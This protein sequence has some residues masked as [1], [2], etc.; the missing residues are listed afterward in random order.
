[1]LRAAST[2]KITIA[3]RRGIKRY[4]IDGDYYQ[5]EYEN[6]LLDSLVKDL[7]EAFLGVKPKIQVVLGDGR[8]DLALILADFFCGAMRWDEEDYLGGWQDVHKYPFSHG[9]RRVG[10]RLPQ[11]LL[12]EYENIYRVFGNPPGGG[13][14]SGRT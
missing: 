12:D 8:R 4:G 3:H 9:Y 2:I 1:M 7:R 10:P 5:R 13:R 6:H 14:F 11:R